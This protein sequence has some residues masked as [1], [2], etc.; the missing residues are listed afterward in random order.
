MPSANVKVSVTGPVTPQLSVEF[1]PV[2]IISGKGAFEVPFGRRVVLLWRVVGSIPGAAYKITLAPQSGTLIINGKH[3]I[4]KRNAGDSTL[5][6]G[7]R[8]F[9]IRQ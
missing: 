3:P 1:E 7:Y 5:G 8:Y 4:E 2:T 9:S 6:A